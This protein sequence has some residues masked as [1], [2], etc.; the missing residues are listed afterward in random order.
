MGLADE[1][2]MEI[3][4]KIND[5]VE[6]FLNGP[7]VR[8]LEDL[9]AEHAFHDVYS[10]NATERAMLSRRYM[11]GDRDALSVSVSGQSLT[12]SN[13]TILQGGGGIYE[14]DI[15]Q[16]GYSNYRQPGPRP[17][18]DK[19]LAA[20]INSGR[21]DKELA[22]VLRNAGFDVETRSGGFEALAETLSNAGFD[23]FASGWWE[24]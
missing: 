14:T 6:Q 15:V 7:A 17:F 16:Q 13:T 23:V 24:H 2:L 1:Y 9:I 8:S 21:A 3:K 10:Y 22:E 11:I 19:A 12:I 20:Y 4:P 5:A 18:M